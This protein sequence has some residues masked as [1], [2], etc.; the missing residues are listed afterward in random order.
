MK[1]QK[2][3]ISIGGGTRLEIAG[4][5]ALL[6]DFL[7]IHVIPYVKDS[8]PN[9]LVWDVGP[10]ELFDLSDIPTNTSVLILI[11]E[12]IT[13]LPT[14]ECAGLFSKNEHPDMFAAAIRQVARGEQYLS[15]SLALAYL[16]SQQAEGREM[17]NSVLEAL[18]DREQEILDLITQ[19]QS[20]KSIA[21]HLYLSIRQLKATSPEFTQSWVCIRAPK[22]CWLR[23]K[24]GN[25]T[26]VSRAT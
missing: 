8:P 5:S 26:Y 4:L 25:F 3:I 16:K 15:P 13:E 14:M 7:G 22:R 1:Q 9:V 18:S 10:N 2:M 21:G 24:A 20:N 12:S 17:R 6:S 19:G 23:S 11:D